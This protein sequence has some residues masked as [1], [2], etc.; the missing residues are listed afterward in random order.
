VVP[1]SNVLFASEMIGAVRG[2]DPDSGHHYDDTRR[3]IDAADITDAARQQIFA[4]NVRRVFPRL[5]VPS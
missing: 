3:Y 4:G 2:V 1:T 5:E